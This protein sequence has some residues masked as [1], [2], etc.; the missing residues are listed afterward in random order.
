MTEEQTKKLAKDPDGLATYE[1][2]AN[3]IGTL[4]EA[5]LDTAVENMT[6][7]DLTGQFLASAAR[8]LHA[9]DA[10]AYAE[11]VRRLVAAAID[12]DRNHA[13]LPD[14][15][16]AIYGDD[17]HSRATVLCQSDDNFRRIFKRLCPS[18]PI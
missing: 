5:D 6:R 8:Y 12:R 4:D 2:L 13:Y 9:I 17:Y 18:S 7:V 16:T 1:F 3:N 10:G 11:P 15:V 14:L